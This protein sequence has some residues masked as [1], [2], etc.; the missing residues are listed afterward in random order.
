M[1]FGMRLE[2]LVSGGRDNYHGRGNRYTLQT[3]KP[4]K[5]L[6]LIGLQP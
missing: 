3:G 5:T 2:S 4:L 6:D 1:Q